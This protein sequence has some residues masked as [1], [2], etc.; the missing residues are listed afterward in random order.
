MQIK[1]GE[2]LRELRHRD[3]RTQEELAQALGVT[4]QAV[5]RWEKGACYPDL[6]LI[7]PLANYFGLSID[8]LFGYQ[9]ERAKK[10]DALIERIQEMNRRNNGQDVCMD[11]CVH[12]A[13]EAAA[14]FPGNEKIMLCL[15][16]VLYNAGY[17]RHGE[18]HLTDEEGYDAYDAQRHRAYAEWQE[19]IR[20]YEKLLTTLPYGDERHQA[21]R[22][23]IQ[24]YANLGESEKAAAVAQTAPPLS[25]CRE[26]LRP[27]ARDGHER[28]LAYGETLLD[29]VK[30]LSHLMVASVMTRSGHLTPAEAAQAVQNAIRLY[31][32]ICTDG[33]YG[34]HHADLV[35]LHLYLSEHLW[36][37]GK[38]DEAFAALDAAL[39]HARRF[40]DL[41]QRSEV[42][43][44]APLLAAVRKTI[45]AAPETGIAAGLP[46]D[47]P[48]WR[49]PDCSAVKAELQANPR[50]AAWVKKAR[51]AADAP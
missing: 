48:W 3:G 28:A 12:L 21:T 35:C 37:D 50:W 16:S 6:E 10:I 22:E 1:L 24:L 27:I 5:S 49:V 44:T 20:L 14:E 7:P 2:R 45:S 38:Q 8:E 42:T 47:W 33:Q 36:L 31:D 4:A 9:N 43:Y 34:L 18:H 11:E 26:F 30:A 23:L 25:G 17:V 41:C 15:A 39:T 40:D 46:E 32:L 51:G 29:V 19:A 13:R